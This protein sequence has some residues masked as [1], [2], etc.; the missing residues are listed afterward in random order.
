MRALL[1]CVLFGFVEASAQV[2]PPDPATFDQRGSKPDKSLLIGWL[3]SDVPREV[4]WAARFIARDAVKDLTPD[5][6]QRLASYQPGDSLGDAAIQAVADALIQL[7]VPV[8]ADV[9]MNLWPKFPALTM[10]L[11]ARADN[12]RAALMK[13]L[14]SAEDDEVFLAAG[15]L[16][17]ASPPPGFARALLDRMTVRISFF[18]ID[19]GQER[20]LQEM[21]ILALRV[22]EHVEPAVSPDFS[23]WPRIREYWLSAESHDGELLADGVESVR[24]L[25]RGG[26]SYLPVKIGKCTGNRVDGYASSLLTQIA[27]QPRLSSSVIVPLDSAKTSLSK[28]I[29]DFLTQ[30]NRAFDELIEAL[31]KHGR[32]T[33]DE[34][35]MAV[36]HVDASVQDHRQSKGGGLPTLPDVTRFRMVAC[37]S[38]ATCE[39][40]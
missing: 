36:L 29:D 9:A 33:A 38:F 30:E 6:T 39:K 25:Y 28:L 19:P 3:H 22:K 1:A 20:S 16:L 2:K 7:H 32:L 13:I 37:G 4:A 11:L 24:A 26:T 31:V 10:I 21:Q 35:K 17:A 14:E 12:N 27:G 40:F 18:V 23:T 5:L 34:A 8:P 15:S